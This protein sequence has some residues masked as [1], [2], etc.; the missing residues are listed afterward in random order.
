MIDKSSDVIRIEKLANSESR[1]Y[2]QDR[3]TEA[4]ELE[5]PVIIHKIMAI[6]R[7]D[8]DNRNNDLPHNYLNILRKKISKKV[9]IALDYH[10]NE[11]KDNELSQ[12]K[13]KLSKKACQ[14]I[15][16]IKKGALN[17]N[18]FITDVK[19]SFTINSCGDHADMYES[20]LILSFDEMISNNQEL[21]RNIK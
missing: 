12:N 16:T 9:E 7:M 13:Y 21:E 1:N 17:L 11:K 15:D 10:S 2:P 8:F 20:I 4:I 18:G 3:I 19:M 5:L 6:A 14:E